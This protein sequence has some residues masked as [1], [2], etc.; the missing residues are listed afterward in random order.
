M[1]RGLL[2]GILV[3]VCVVS[4][5]RCEEWGDWELATISNST[6]DH[7][8]FQAQATS[9]GSN[10]TLTLSCSDQSGFE[11]RVDKT[12]GTRSPPAQKMYVLIDGKAPVAVDAVPTIPGIA[13]PS[14][15][16]HNA[17]PVESA[18]SAAHRIGIR[19]DEGFGESSTFYFDFGNL[20][21]GQAH[22]LKLCPA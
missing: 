5:A 14:L 3:G 7:S 15:V 22:L 4:G 6:G 9:E 13:F 18:V 8:K 12:D 20:K 17:E 19:F 10:A 11:I 21:A 16:A 2:F 1:Y